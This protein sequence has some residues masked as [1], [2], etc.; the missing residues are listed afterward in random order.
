M[1]IYPMQHLWI[2]IF[3]ISIS[4]SCSTSSNKQDATSEIDPAVP[5]FTFEHS[6]VEFTVSDTTG[7]SLT[8][9]KHKDS[10]YYHHFRFRKPENI[11]SLGPLL[12]KISLMWREA[13]SKIDIRLRSLSLGY[14]L[15]YDDVL[16]NQIQAFSTSNRWHN[17][18]RSQGNDVDY[19]LVEEIMHTHNIY[20][21]DELLLDFRYEITGFSIEKVGF[22]QPERLIGL[23]FD[24]SLT[25]PVPYMVWIQ[26]AKTPVY[27]R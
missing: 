8:F 18:L 24:E 14:P 13:E 21:L 2:V 5:S 27:D 3:I 7:Y 9:N 12:P 26:V 22:V 1:E 6:Q 11:S 25:I 19:P 23:G 4:I 10:T 16:T 15:E 20:P 17:H